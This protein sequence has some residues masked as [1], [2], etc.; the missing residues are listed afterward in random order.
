[1]HK[2]YNAQTVVCLI[3]FKYAFMYLIFI[4]VRGTNKQWKKIRTIIVKS[5]S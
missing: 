2:T 3:N 4:E 5:C 1:M